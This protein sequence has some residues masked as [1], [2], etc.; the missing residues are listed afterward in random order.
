[1]ISFQRL[2]HVLLYA[3]VSYTAILPSGKEVQKEVP[4]NQIDGSPCSIIAGSI[5]DSFP[6]VYT[7]L[8]D[9]LNNTGIFKLQDLEFAWKPGRDTL[10][11][12]DKDMPSDLAGLTSNGYLSEGRFRDTIFISRKYLRE[13]SKEYLASVIIHEC[14]HAFINWC[15]LSYS[16]KQNGVNNKFLRSRFPSHWKWLT[17]GPPFISADSQH[18]LMTENYMERMSKSIYKYTNPGSTELLR[19]NLSWSLA[20]GGL[21]ET[22][23]WKRSDLDTCIIHSVNGWARNMYGTGETVFVYGSCNTVQKKQLDTLG[24]RLPCQ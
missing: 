10:V 8:Q 23:Q 15:L 20:W 22:P 19:T 5:K 9:T 14:V 4:T 12:V 17:Q 11:F 1:M 18:I 13:A 7:F 6:C 24:L 16:E 2:M 21:Y 3:G